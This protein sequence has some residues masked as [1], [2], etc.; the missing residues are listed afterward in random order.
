MA[1]LFHGTTHANYLKILEEGFSPENENWNCS[2][3]EETY[4]WDLEKIREGEH[5]EEDEEEWVL[6]S[7]LRYAFD[8]AQICAAIQGVGEQTLVVLQVEVDEDDV[9]EDLSCPNMSYASTVMNDVLEKRGTIVKA[10]ICEKG[11]N[12]SLRVF[13]IASLFA[14]NDWIIQHHVDEAEQEAIDMINENSIHL[15][16]DSMHEFDWEEIQIAVPA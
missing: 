6:G 11:Y 15:E 5:D 4:F 10:F 8:S 9:H 12:P 16:A 2:S 1:T 7:A 3:Y 14:N 13:Y